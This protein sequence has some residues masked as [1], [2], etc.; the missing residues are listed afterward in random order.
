MATPTLTAAITL[1][2]VAAM[3]GL[4]MAIF[5][6][7]NRFPPLFLI[8]AHGFFALAAL[9]LAIWTIGIPGT[10]SI[11]VFGVVMVVIGAVGGLFLISFQFRD[12]S[13][14]KLVVVLHGLAVVSG[15]SCLLIGLLQ[16]SR[17][18]RPVQWFTWVSG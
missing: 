10:P 16:M 2:L 15:V 1:F 11:V 5:I 7:K 8:V 17:L 4:T 12:E 3:W 14:P 13:Q 9:G 6:F 18:A